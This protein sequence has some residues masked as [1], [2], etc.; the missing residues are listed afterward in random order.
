MDGMHGMGWI[1][2]N[3][4]III[5]AVDAADAADYSATIIKHTHGSANLLL[6]ELLELGRDLHF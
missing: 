6:P 3:V 5:I 2:G 1:D 4:I